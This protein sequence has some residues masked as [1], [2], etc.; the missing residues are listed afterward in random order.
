M[1]PLVGAGILS[2][3]VFPLVALSVRGERPRSALRESA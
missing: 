3:L 2:V 1:K